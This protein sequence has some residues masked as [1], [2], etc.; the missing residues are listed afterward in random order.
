VIQSRIVG[1]QHLRLVLRQPFGDLL[2]DAI[3]FFVE[4]PE[5]WLGIRQI[6]SVY[7]LDINEYQGARNIQFIL[8]YIEK[9][10]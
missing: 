6:K 4:Q 5:N 10:A 3:A 9:M 7:K 8:Q 1:K 2:I